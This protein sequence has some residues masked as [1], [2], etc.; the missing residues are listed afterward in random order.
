[1]DLVALYESAILL[2]HSVQPKIGS[3][4]QNSNL[5]MQIRDGRSHGIRVSFA[6]LDVEMVPRNFRIPKAFVDALAKKYESA[7]DNIKSRDVV[8]N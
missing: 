7:T 4:W 3:N 5:Q 6:L 8:G 2:T 1:M